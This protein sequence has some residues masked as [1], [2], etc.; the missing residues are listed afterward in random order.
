MVAKVNDNWDLAGQGIGNVTH[1]LLVDTVA[2]TVEDAV[3]ALQITHVVVGIAGDHVA[4]QGDALP[5]VA[6]VSVV[7]T[8]A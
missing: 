2:T 8:F 1:I 4:V 6:D 7:V 3:K 5:A